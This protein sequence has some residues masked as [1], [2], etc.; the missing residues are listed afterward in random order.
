M[1]SAYVVLLAG[2]IGASCGHSGRTAATRP[3][4]LPAPQPIFDRQIRNALDAGEGDYQT[5]ILRERLAAEPENLSVRLELAEAYRRRGYSDIA[6]EHCRLAAARFPDSAEA[7]TALVHLS[8]DLKLHKEAVATLEKY[9]AAHPPVSPGLVSWMGILRDELGAW[10][11]GEK[12]HRQALALAPKA[13]YLHNNL[14][15]N[16][17]MQGRRQEAAEAFREALKLSPDYLLARNNLG[18]ALAEQSEQA[19]AELRRANDPASAHNN[20]AALLIEQGRYQDAHRELEL[21]LGYNRLHPAAL[22]NLRLLSELDGK[23][24]TM[25]AAPVES[26]W[27]R[28]KAGLR[29]WFVGPAP[30]ENRKQGR[31]ETAKGSS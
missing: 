4:A 21:A 2:T 24:A 19:L 25:R 14:G 20:M 10:G 16:L 5:R 28:L 18:A 13:E 31:V 30:A 9:L 6:L 12:S 8:R 23:P 7:V 26:R 29:S 11:E 22:N 1:R 27:H 17:L 3:A 15:Y